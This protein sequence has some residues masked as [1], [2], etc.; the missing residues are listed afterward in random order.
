[1]R[2]KYF[3]RQFKRD[4]NERKALFRSLLNALV[5]HESIRTT[6]AKAKAIKGDADRL[7]TKSKR[8]NSAYN[9]LTRVLNNEAAKKIINDLGPRFSDRA[10]G[11]TRITRVGKRIVD[12]ASMVVLEWTDKQDLTKVKNEEQKKVAK[13]KTKKEVKEAVV[14][15]KQ[16]DKMV[17]VP[18]KKAKMKKEKTEK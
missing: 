17:K 2:K 1:M 13:K 16:R 10:G 11:Y 3:G 14:T 12:N 7:I 8:S 15:E 4:A 6:E 18:A 9:T 5:L